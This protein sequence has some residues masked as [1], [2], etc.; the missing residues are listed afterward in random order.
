MPA[1]YAI[2]WFRRDLRLHDNPAVAAAIESGLPLWPI[3][4]HD[5]AAAFAPGAASRWWLHHALQDLATELDNHDLKLTLFAGDTSEILKKL[6]VKSSRIFCNY[7]YEPGEE[8]FIKKI[9]DK[10]SA[11]HGSVLF[12]PQSIKPY[13]VFTPFYNFCQKLERPKPLQ[14][15]LS[16]AKAGKGVDKGVVLGELNLL[17]KENWA[18]GFYKFW[19]PT[20]A[21]GLARLKKMEAGQADYKKTRDLVFEDGTSMLSPYLAWGQLGPREVAEELATD[22]ALARQLFWREFAIHTLY[23]HPHV[24]LGQPLKK[25]WTRFPW[26]E[27]ERLFEAW[28]RG[29]TGY[30]LVDAAMRQLWT[31]G[32]MHNR[33]RMVAGSFLVKHLLIPWQR[34][35]EWFWET[36]VDADLANNSFGW[37]WIAG[38]GA[39]AAPY[40]RIFNP[41]LQK[42]KF[43]PDET[44]CKQWI[45]EL[46]TAKYPKPIVTAQKGREAA[47]AAYKKFKKK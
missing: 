4:I 18:H 20:R 36:L 28:K 40:F 30:P 19:K 29:Q 7:T 33:A 14:V 15:W 24:G 34:G 3:Y 45:P 22:G 31:I 32:W 44:Y 13:K 10:V 43:D 25:E 8:S 1:S 12:S 5:D 2:I 26:K 35:Q 16:Y 11:H 6:S 17:P 9:G 38:C 37:Q 46:G 21:G 41:T 42:E 23:H 27:N 47:L 39:D